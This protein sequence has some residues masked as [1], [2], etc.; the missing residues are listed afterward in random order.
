MVCRQ[1]V[2]FRAMTAANPTRLLLAQH[3]L[4]YAAVLGT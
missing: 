2:G 3:L 1:R 4:A